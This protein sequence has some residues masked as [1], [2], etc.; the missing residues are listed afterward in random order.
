MSGSDA[1]RRI[2]LAARRALL[3]ERAA[4]ER[5]QVRAVAA[6]LAPAARWIARGIGIVQWLRG[7]RGPAV[8]AALG[9]PVLAAL[10]H[11][12]ARS[13]ARWAPALLPLVRIAVRWMRARH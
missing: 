7:H 4:M 8:T 9:A 6:D 13:A 1:Q 5:R 3:V 10:L 12:Q 2:V 11:R